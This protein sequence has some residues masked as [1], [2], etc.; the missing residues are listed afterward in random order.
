MTPLVATATDD[1]WTAWSFDPL[2]LT[3][4]VVAVV[5]FAQGWRRLRRRRPELAPWSRWPPF[6]AGVAI[7]VLAVVSPL[8]A[9]AEEYLQ[10]AHMLQHVLLADLGVALAVVAVRGPLSL[11]F[12]PRDL[13]APLARR[14]GLRR[15][16]S[17]VLRPHVAVTL[18][19]GVLVAWHLPVLYDAALRHPLVHRLEHLSLVAVGALVWTL[20]VDPAGHGRLTVNGRIG[21]AALMLWAGQMLA[22]VFVFSFHPYYDVYVEQPERLLGLSPLTDQKLAGV[23]MMVEQALTLGTALVLLLLA[24]RR[25]RESAVP[26]ATPEPV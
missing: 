20:V 11:F 18:W 3:G 25:A 13:L 8:D 14:Q 5:F 26:R 12:L 4:A 2:V 1:L 10:S 15:A 6:L 23:V 9:I 21:L 22:Y 19:L 24:A 7:L 16:L 17:F